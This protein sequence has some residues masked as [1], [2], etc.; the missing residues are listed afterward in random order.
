[1]SPIFPLPPLPHSERKYIEDSATGELVPVILEDSLDLIL[2]EMHA[3]IDFRGFDNT[4]LTGI[5]CCSTSSGLPTHPP[6]TPFGVCTRLG[7]HLVGGHLTSMGRSI[8]SSAI[9]TMSS[10]SMNIDRL[11]NPIL[12]PTSAVW[13]NEEETLF[14]VE[15]GN[16]ILKILKNN[17]N[18]TSTSITTEP[19]AVGNNNHAE[20]ECDHHLET[21]P[22]SI[23]VAIPVVSV[24]HCHQLIF[25]Q[26][27]GGNHGLSLIK[28]QVFVELKDMGYIVMRHYP[29]KKKQR[30]SSAS[31][32]SVPPS[33]SKLLLSSI[34]GQASKRASSSATLSHLV[35][36]QIRYLVNYTAKLFNKIWNNRRQ[37]GVC[38]VDMSKC[39]SYGNRRDKE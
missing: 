29:T 13:L 27:G 6:A 18:I 2:S 28:Y 5:F 7:G 31:M 21:A 8:K 30:I 14:L 9:K 23:S 35:S 32:P 11:K 4:R 38:I 34:D 26:G 16:L 1:M 39:K 15:R 19:S 37:S 17:S 22:A 10:A 33:K 25:G 20:W 12:N 24:Q 3:K 36:T